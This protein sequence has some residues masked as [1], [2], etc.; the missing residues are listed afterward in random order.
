MLYPLG[1]PLINTPFQRGGRRALRTENRFNGFSQLG[2]N[3]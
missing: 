3:R 2:K 1:G